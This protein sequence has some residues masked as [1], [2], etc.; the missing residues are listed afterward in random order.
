MDS[1]ILIRQFI[2]AINDCRRIYVDKSIE[3]IMYKPDMDADSKS[4]FLDEVERLF[5][6]LVIKVFVE[7]AWSDLVW[8]RGEGLLGMVL[9]EEL[10]R[11]KIR[12]KDLGRV[13]D[14]MERVNREE[15]WQTVLEPFVLLEE[16][17]EHRPELEAG[18]LR[19]ANI[20]AKI[21][22]N[23]TPETIGQLKNLK[24]QLHQFLE[25][26]PAPPKPIDYSN[27]SHYNDFQ[28][29]KSLGTEKAADSASTSSDAVEAVESNSGSVATAVEDGTGETKK[30]AAPMQLDEVLAELDQLVGIESVKDEVNGLV[31][32]LKVQTHRIAAGLPESKISLH[33]VFEGNPGTG[34]TTVAR[35][36]GRV[37]GAMGVLDKGHL[38]ETDRSGLVA[39]FVGQTATKTN[40]IID[41][42]LDGVLFIDEAYSLMSGDGKDTFGA[43]AMQILLKRAE[44]DRDRLIVIL[45]GYS[46]PMKRLLKTNPGL[47]SRFARSFNF[48]D[49]EPAELTKIFELLAEKNHYVVTAEV[50]EK[51]MGLAASSIQSK[52]EHFGNGRLMRNLFEAAIRNLADRVVDVAELTPELLTT[53]DVSDLEL[54]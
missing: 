16:L 10:L 47:S 39:E 17:D 42:A 29:R 2:D 40:K 30:V 20:T 8:S 13:I 28:K 24:W 51:L 31:N 32:F 14:Q 36:L 27:Y 19:I 11:Q 50:R 43:E 52:D 34:K 45:A 54:S 53:F 7:V 1:D 15:S 18:L 35:I 21:D 23:V 6:R 33:M 3:C 12:E 46:D 9:A 44:D 25:P 5:N 48:P 26:T 38:I 49:Y 4:S 37:F 22:G 41:E